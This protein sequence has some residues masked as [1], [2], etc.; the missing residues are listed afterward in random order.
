MAGILHEYLCT[1]MRFI[2]VTE[3][4]C[5]FYKVRAMSTRQVQETITG[6]S[7]YR[8]LRKKHE[9][10]DEAQRERSRIP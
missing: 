5:V 2:V 3:T 7:K 4:G 10:Y 9:K 6:K 1:F 8:L